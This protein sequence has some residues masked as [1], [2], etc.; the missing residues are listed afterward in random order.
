M[1][2]PDA[3]ETMIQYS[4]S[5][6]HAWFDPTPAAETLESRPSARH[7][8]EDS[9]WLST[10]VRDLPNTKYYGPHD[11]DRQGLTFSMNHASRDCSIVGAR[12]YDFAVEPGQG[13]IAR[14]LPTERSGR[15][16]QAQSG[17]RPRSITPGPIS[18]TCWRQSA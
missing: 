15:F 3:M 6:D 11:F 7:T 4:G 9:R 2:L 8:R 17:S 16:L 10:Q 1:G 5:N 14:R 18:N 13:C 12:L